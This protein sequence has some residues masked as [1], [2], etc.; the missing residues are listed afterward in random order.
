MENVGLMVGIRN[1][2]MNERRPVRRWEINRKIDVK[3]LKWGIWSECV[4]QGIGISALA[5]VNMVINI[6]IT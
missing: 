1:D 5:P 3:G 4:Q 6:R 2:H